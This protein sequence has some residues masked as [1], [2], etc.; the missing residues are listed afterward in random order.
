MRVAAPLALAL[1]LPAGYAGAKTERVAVVVGHNTGND[2][3]RPLRFA[4]RDAAKVGRALIDVGQVDR[5]ALFL[6]NAPTVEDVDDA[7][8]RA[9]ARVR[10]ARRSPD[11]RALLFF[12]FSGHSDGEAIELGR[13]RLSFAQL[14]LRI[15]ATDADLRL[16]VLDACRSG[17]AVLR[18]GGEPAPAFA[19]QMTD[20]LATSGE[21]ILSSS[22]ADEVALESREMRGSYFTHH[23][24]S[25]LRGGADTSGDGRVTLHELY[26]YAYE[27]TVASSAMTL[28]GP[29]HPTYSLDLSG[30]GEL[31]LGFL[32]TA[33]AVLVLPDHTDRGLITDL[34]QDQVVAEVG[35]GPGRA[36]ALA[37]GRYSVQLW[38]GKTRRHIRLSLP[39]GVRRALAWNELEP[40]AAR[41]RASRKGPDVRRSAREPAPEPTNDLLLHAGGGVSTGVADTLGAALSFRLGA[42]LRKRGGW[43]GGWGGALTGYHANGS[44]GA[45]SEAM[46]QVR[47]GYGISFGVDHVSAEVGLEA[48]PGLIWQRAG[49]EY[50]GATWLLGVC[51]AARLRWWTWRQLAVELSGEWLLAA[52]EVDR[53][54]AMR[55]FP[56]LRLGLTLRL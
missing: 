51:P 11:T 50:A 22:A 9:A 19:I 14:K 52:L 10:E 53:G 6:L 15:A 32:D 1:L 12:F 37:P 49:G 8:T 16:L 25:G 38:R 18:K 29:H 3:A 23:L 31:V 13:E 44:D 21:V 35:A 7:L 34:K 28:D 41:N 24:V 45:Y 48:G 47:A 4:E 2:G 46:L 36:V 5:D 56:A 42:A 26:R 54:F 55:S 40:T 43:R 33:D 27:Q 20:E 17:G 39:H 30:R